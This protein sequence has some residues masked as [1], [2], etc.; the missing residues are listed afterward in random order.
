MFI[1][2]L[3]ISFDRTLYDWYTGYIL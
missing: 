2:I 3:A 1:I